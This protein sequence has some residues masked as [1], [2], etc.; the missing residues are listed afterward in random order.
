MKLSKFINSFLLGIIL[1]ST[2]L[3][4]C[5]SIYFQY[6]NFQ[7]NKQQ[8]KSNFLEVQK[9][10]LKEQIDTVFTIIEKENETFEKLLEKQ[11][12]ISNVNDLVKEHQE[13][14]LIWLSNYKIKDNG[15]IFVN[16]MEALPLIYN[17]KIVETSQKYPHMEIFK[18]QLEAIKNIN[19]GFFN[20][21][22]KKL[23]SQ[24]EYD[25]ISFVRKYEKYNWIIGT[26]VY[27]DEVEESLK[28]NEE[29]FKKTLINQI[30]SM[31]I[32]FIFVLF[33]IYFISK[34]LSKYIKNNIENLTIAFE[35]ASI[36][37]KK[38]DTK[39]LTFKEFISLANNLNITLESKNETEKKLQDH[40]QIINENII[41]SSTD[42]NGF[43]TDASEAFCNISGFSKDELVG[44]THGLIRHQDTPNEFYA[45]MWKKLLNGEIWEGEIKNIN[46]KNKDY[47]VHTVIKPIFKN[48]KI[49]G[50][51]A[52]KTNIT[53]K[54]HIEYL[55]ITDDLTQLYNRRY[56]N[57][58]IIEEINRAKRED[59]F[60]SLLIIDVDYFKQYNDTYG[61][62]AGDFA[63]EK[64]AQILK[65]NTNRA[66][67][68]AFRL[69]GEEFGIINT[70]SK[71]KVVEFATLLKNEIENLQIEHKSSEISK[72][73]TISIG[74]VSRKGQN[75]SDDN[76]LYKEADDCLYQAKGLGRNSIFI[77]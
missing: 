72:Y 53:D 71:E 22:F 13:N 48:Q 46:K 69:G 62:Q 70:L 3:T 28:K 74:I 36:E 19:G 6:L 10:N 45:N 38:I 41:I 29:I 33:F 4:F 27:L 35:K 30:I 39:D 9:N 77:L 8:I 51:T 21:K 17:G 32:L 56:F 14:L 55:S 73:L 31:I 63:L 37:N 25:K 7:N 61:H 20:Y 58:Q 64:V 16:S 76:T 50:Y 18:K 15:Y 65:K 43:I 40:I 75:I 49:I 24:Q 67:D 11:N 5:I 60:F 59:T 54:K 66:S 23:N 57:T 12:G 1:F 34:K 42:K 52:I 68:F 44:N 2:L 26:G 47:W